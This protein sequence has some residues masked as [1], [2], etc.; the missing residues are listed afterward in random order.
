M[1]VYQKSEIFDWIS[2]FKAED[3]EC[4]LF[5]PGD[6][7]NDILVICHDVQRE[8]QIS[9][10]FRSTISATFEF[11]KVPEVTDLLRV[12]DEIL[13]RNTWTNIYFAICKDSQCKPCYNASGL[14]SH[15]YE[16]RILNHDRIKQNFMKNVF[17][18]GQKLIFSRL[19][20]TVTGWKNYVLSL[21][22]NGEMQNSNQTKVLIL[23]GG[24]GNKV[25]HSPFE[26]GFCQDPD[27]YVEDRQAVDY[28][29]QEQNSNQINWRVK[30]LSV[31]DG[32]FTRLVDFIRRGQYSFIVLAYCYAYSSNLKSRLNADGIIYNY[33]W[34]HMDQNCPKCLDIRAEER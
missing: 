15:L 32:D 13:V 21:I 8:E 7:R 30:D 11:K 25:G 3:E 2:A 22:E 31:F 4:L 5:G 1:A 33:L 29:M 6:N 23:S 9:E 10:T 27:F 19:K 16:K 24:H 17:F 34:V 14:Q 20:V 18:K 12:Y 28:F 26:C